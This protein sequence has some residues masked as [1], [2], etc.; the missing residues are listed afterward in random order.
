MHKLVTAIVV[1]GAA[2][3][4]AAHAQGFAFTNDTL[5]L[6]NCKAASAAE[7]SQAIALAQD[8]LSRFPHPMFHVHVDGLAPHQGSRDESEQAM[9]DWDAA[10][11]LAVGY[12]VTSNTAYLDHADAII[13]AWLKSFQP[14]FNPVDET[15]LE[16]LFLAADILGEAM[17]RP[18]YTAWQAFAAKLSTG[19][20]A[21]IDKHA[22]AADGRQSQ[23]IKLAAMAAYVT[24]DTGAI[25]HVESAFTAQ[26]GANVQSDGTVAD[27]AK[28]DALH[29]V[30]F[31]LEPLVVA[32]LAAHDHGENWY[33]IHASSGASMASALLWLSP[34]AN[35]TQTNQERAGTWTPR[36]SASLYLYASA[37][38]RQWADLAYQLGGT[39]KLWQRLEMGMS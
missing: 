8:A 13:D 26:L 15:R 19:Y 6:N 18:L 27:Y 4:V 34:Y 3:G 17:P 29:S 32:A 7:R 20:L 22:T 21:E 36:A 30:V 10:R 31:D 24:A 23:R 25:G 38:D 12:C 37:L 33:G 9:R 16:Q 14:N 11:D 35:G 39:P 1:L 28:N 5:A 2:A